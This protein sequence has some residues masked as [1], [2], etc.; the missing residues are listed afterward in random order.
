MDVRRRQ[1]LSALGVAALGSASGCNRVRNEVR[2]RPTA[3]EFDFPPGVSISGVEEPT[4]LVAGHLVQ[5]QS[6][7][8][9]AEFVDRSENYFNDGESGRI[10][11]AGTPDY[12]RW[13]IDHQVSRHT[14]IYRGSGVDYAERRVEPLKEL[15]AGDTRGDVSQAVIDSVGI[16]LRNALEAL[17]G[18]C[19]LDIRSDGEVDIA[20]F[21]IDSSGHPLA[22]SV[23]QMEISIDENGAI[24]GFDV[25]YTALRDTAVDAPY[26]REYHYSIDVGAEPPPT[27]SG[28]P[29]GARAFPAFG[30]EW[31][32]GGRVM[33][34]TN[35]GGGPVR[36][37][38]FGVTNLGE[39][40]SMGAG[41]S[42]EPPFPPGETRYLFNRDDIIVLA[43]SP[44]DDASTVLRG[45]AHPLFRYRDL[46]G[47][48][49][50]PFR[51]EYSTACDRFDCS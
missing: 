13:E 51:Y 27:L 18:N 21:S 23:D 50:I 19:T 12:N 30:I 9:T 22:E 39:S 40:G 36:D 33:E 45:D 16:R 47:V 43:D 32:D 5:L 11:S 35:T 49:S 14:T 29:D 20:V 41:I 44:P 25:V 28:L 42:F 7:T 38:D 6:M 15:Y 24:R 4:R 48:N 1:Y 8:F 3:T 2:N 34:V 10:R 31:R 37:Y 17:Y 46:S 26:T